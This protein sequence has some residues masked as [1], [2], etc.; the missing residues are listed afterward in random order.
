M[1]DMPNDFWSGWVIVLTV[2][3]FAGL[4][5]L[6]L[7]VYFLNRSGEREEVDT[8]WDGDLREGSHPA[9]MWWFWMI[10]AAMVFS[11]VYLMLYPG[12]GSFEGALRWSQG[13]RVEHSY[14]DYDAA[15]GAERARIAAL[16]LAELQANPKLMRTA[17]GIFARNC[18]ACHGLEAQGQASLFPSLID[19]AWQWGG[20]PEQVEQTIRQGRR[21][22]MVPWR[23]ALGEQGVA[24]VADYVLA[25]GGGEVAGH[26]GEAAFRQF[27]SACHG[28]DGSGNP[29][30]GAPSL[31]DADWLYGG[32]REA[33]MT[34]VSEGRNGEMPAFESRLD[35]FQIRLLTAWLTRAGHAASSKSP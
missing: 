34:S 24:Q 29:L 26:P 11:V 21:A 10:L 27:C 12:L 13:H 3:S 19:E 18:A 33:V 16:P 2:L 17:A 6:V 22:V 31:R 15:F 30:L 25:L 28:P 1:A 20:T 7:S 32:S 4:A 23:A 5:W 9:P 35:D 8:V 14:H